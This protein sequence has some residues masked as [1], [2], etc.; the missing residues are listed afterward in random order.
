MK[1]LGGVLGS[2]YASDSNKA[3]ADIAHVRL[4]ANE[5]EPAWTML[6]KAT[7]R[8]VPSFDRADQVDASDGDKGG[9]AFGKED[10]PALVKSFLDFKHRAKALAKSG[11]KATA[12]AYREAFH[13]KWRRR[14]RLEKAG[15]VRRRPP[16]DRRRRRRGAVP[17]RVR[18][19]RRVTSSTHHTGP[20]E[21]EYPPY[22]PNR[23]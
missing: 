8:A 7:L 4:L 18:R 12:D 6:N 17:R 10:F 3:L 13:A 23:T 11:G 14:H 1:G 21:V 15:L 19:R 20:L 5:D 22:R 9:K 2:R 16:A